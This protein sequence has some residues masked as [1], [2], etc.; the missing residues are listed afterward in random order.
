M[1]LHFCVPDEVGELIKV[2]A[3]SKGVSVSKYLADLAQ[4]E[5]VQGWPQGYFERVIG[6]WHGEPLERPDQGTLET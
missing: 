3:K 6:S 1:R 2:R 4:R 5:V